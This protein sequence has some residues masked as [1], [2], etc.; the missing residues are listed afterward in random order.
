MSLRIAPNVAVARNSHLMVRAA[1]CPR[2]PYTPSVS[3]TLTRACGS[4]PGTKCRCR[5]CNA[6]TVTGRLLAR[7]RCGMSRKR[8]RSRSIRSSRPRRR[9]LSS[10]P[11]CC[12]ADK[13]PRGNAAIRPTRSGAT[14]RPLAQLTQRRA[15]RPPLRVRYYPREPA[16]CSSV[17]PPAGEV[18]ISYQYARYLDREVKIADHACEFSRLQRNRLGVKL[19]SP[20]RKT[21][22]PMGESVGASA[23]R[24]ADPG[25]MPGRSQHASEWP[26]LQALFETQRLSTARDHTSFAQLSQRAGRQGLNRLGGQLWKPLIVA[27]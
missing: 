10:L 13:A 5:S 3:V 6:S 17:V 18:R 12:G 27:F 19:D 2:S 4:A 16:A 8:A 15:E 1:A 23:N 26:Q 24:V 7:L 22:C 21:G 25:A 20:L 9:T 14:S 11:C